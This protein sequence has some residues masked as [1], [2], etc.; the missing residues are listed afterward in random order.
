[1]PVETASYIHD[2]VPAN[3]LHTDGLNQADSHLRLI[4]QVLQNSFPN[5]TGPITATAADLQA[6]VPFGGIILWPFPLASIPTNFHLCDGTNG[7]PDLRDRFIVGA[8]FSYGQFTVGGALSTSVDG[9]HTHPGSTIDVQGG[10]THNTTTTISS[11]G[12]GSTITDT[13]GNHNHGGTQAHT[14]TLAEIPSHQ[15]DGG[16]S[17]VTTTNTGVGGLTLGTGALQFFQKTDTSQGGDGGHSH[18]LNLDGAHAHNL[19]V[20]VA[21]SGTGTGTSDLTGQ[22]GHNVTLSP[23][24]SHS[25]SALP[26]YFALYYIMRIA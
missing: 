15:H 16:V 26:P 11:F 18:G 5:V 23:D 17:I 25:H 2:L 3:P 19:T 6:S 4:K 24:G 22:H 9:S 1:M 14:L 12:S 13:Q 8:G 10:H 20:D 7:T 21:V